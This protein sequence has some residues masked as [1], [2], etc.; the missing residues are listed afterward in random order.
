MKIASTVCLLLF[1]T[2]LSW[3]AESLLSFLRDNK[4]G[5]TVSVGDE[6]IS[7]LPGLE[8]SG[9][10]FSAYRELDT[11]R[12]IRSAGLYLRRNT[13]DVPAAELRKVFAEVTR[14]I[15]AECGEADLFEVPNFEDAT[16]RTHSM[17][18]WKNE[19]S[20]LVLQKTESPGR[21]EV[22]V[23]HVDL[24]HFTSNLGADFG[25]FVLEQLETK[26]GKLNISVSVPTPQEPKSDDSTI[27]QDQDPE[28]QGR[29]DGL[30]GGEKSFQ[31]E[32]TSQKEESETATWPLVLGAIAVLGVAAIL[33]RAFM[34]GRAS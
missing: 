19:D 14:V 31:S 17:R 10:Q 5:S 11:D 33:V 30:A 20:I 15:S 32:P 34:R 13:S 18:A 3:G 27:E 16:E 21:L 29:P 4:L 9:H 22:D 8:I 6:G 24:D 1:F 12:S 23:R 2:P 26:S 25:S 7:E 28:P